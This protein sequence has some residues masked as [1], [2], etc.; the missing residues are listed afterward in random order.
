MTINLKAPLV[1]HRSQ[2]I[3]ALISGLLLALA[4]PKPDLGWLAWIALVPLILSLRKAPPRLG[5]GLGFGFGLVANL[6]I[7]NWTV[8]AMHVYGYIPMVQSVS[9]LVLFCAVL[10]VFSGLFGLLLAL[11][12]KRPWH[13]LV[14]APALWVALEFLRTWVFT[15]FPW[16]LLGY[17]QINHLWVIQIA[18][19][20]GVYGVSALVV[21]INSV[22]ALAM[23]LWIEKTWQGQMVSKI[24]VK[25]SAALLGV[26]LVVVVIYG[27]Y[28]IHT[29]D[30][31][32]AEAAQASLVVV[33]GN[34]N[35]AQKWDPSF[36]VL[37]TAK[38]KNMSLAAAQS[39][40]DL[41]IWP[42]TATPFYLFQDPLLTSMVVEG[43]KETHTAH[44]IGS[45]SVENAGDKEP[46]FLNSA[47]LVTPSGEEA[48]RYDKVHLVPFG[49]YV[50]LSRFLPF[51]QR[52]VTAAG[53]FTPGSK[54]SPLLGE[55][56]S[57]GPLICFESIFPEIARS[58]VRQGVDLLVNITN[59]A[60][61]GYSSAPYQ[62]LIMSVF[63]AIENRRPLIRSANTGFSAFIDHRGEILSQTDLFSRE[64]LVKRI[65]LVESF[66]SFYTQNGDIFAGGCL[67]ASIIIL[68][69]KYYRSMLKS[70]KKK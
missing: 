38:Y 11:L 39:K 28:R 60:W 18:D 20:F 5:F 41:I 24:V 68:I 65:P 50:P 16:A 52:L 25:R 61:Y 22:A 63:R 26:L 64:I 2:L 44:L 9:V 51:I 31:Q 47:F 17:S 35:Q 66:M 58:H 36:Q 29:T 53:D 1:T 54:I 43:I 34:I 6:G 12:A 4:F 37:T 42:E 14:L 23:L 46:L 30:K 48:G 40:V 57:V 13:L 8:H 45:P 10:A 69:L 70:F 56:I 19:L 33:Q 15:G 7:I 49:E 21:F 62:T 67:M 3:L 32:S 55:D 27:I 59:D